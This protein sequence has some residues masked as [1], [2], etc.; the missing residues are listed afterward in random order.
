MVD[1]LQAYLD[2]SRQAGLTAQQ[3]LDG[4]PQVLARMDASGL[5]AALT[6]LQFAAAASEQAAAPG[7]AA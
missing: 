5:T 2:Q 4:L 6:R 7:A 3:V 1:P